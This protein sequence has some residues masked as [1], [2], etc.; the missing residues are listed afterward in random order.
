MLCAAAEVAWSVWEEI[1]PRRVETTLVG[2]WPHF[3]EGGEVPTCDSL[4]ICGC[5]ELCQNE[6][7]NLGCVRTGAIEIDPGR[8]RNRKSDGLSSCCCIFSSEGHMPSRNLEYPNAFDLDIE[9]VDCGLQSCQLK[10]L[11]INGGDGFDT[12]GN[13][14]I[15]RL[16]R[17]WW[18]HRFWGRIWCGHNCRYCCWR[19]KAI[20]ASFR[21]DTLEIAR[22]YR[23]VFAL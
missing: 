5:N 20:I 10:V 22:A 14:R 23:W 21:V 2:K 4:F 19:I 17:R 7:D 12:D 15:D 18:I 11:S 13:T 8:Q 1:A 3:C 6:L 9:G 16:W